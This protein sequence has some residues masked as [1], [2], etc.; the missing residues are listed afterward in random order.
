MVSIVLT[1]PWTGPGDGTGPGA[2]RAA[3]QPR[4]LTVKVSYDGGRTWKPATVPTAANG[5]RYLTLTHPARPG[6]AHHGR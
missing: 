3:R 6:P 5:K 4:S 1:G 2:P